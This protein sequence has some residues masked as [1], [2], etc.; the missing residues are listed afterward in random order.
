M[1]AVDLMS[2]NTHVVI[3]VLTALIVNLRYLMY[4]ASLA[5]YFKDLPFKWKLLIAFFIID[6]TYSSSISQL[7]NKDTAAMKWYYLGTA[8]PLWG[9]W[10]GGGLV[11]ILLGPRVPDHWQL[12]FAIPLLFLGLLLATVE[13]APMVCS[14]C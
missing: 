2:Q 7:G 12:D 3:V 13:D 11:G 5:T 8:I 9:I 6:I 14:K 1:A 4:S 10:V